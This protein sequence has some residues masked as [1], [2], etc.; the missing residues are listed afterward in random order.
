[1]MTFNVH[2]YVDASSS[3]KEPVFDHHRPCCYPKWSNVTSTRK[4]REGA[5]ASVTISSC[6]MTHSAAVQK[7][8]AMK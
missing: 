5:T 1:M 3:A 8:A 7:Q 2:W 4:E 6:A